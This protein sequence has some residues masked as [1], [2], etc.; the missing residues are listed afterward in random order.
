MAALNITGPYIP[1]LLTEPML[2]Q[3]YAGIGC[4]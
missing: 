1:F 4:H 3:I 2:I